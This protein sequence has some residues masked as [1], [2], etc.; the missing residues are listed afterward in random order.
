M[1]KVSGSKLISS[2]T[3]NFELGTLN[4]ELGTLNL[5]LGTLNIGI[6]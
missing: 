6:V 3:L 5:E 2:L 1:F 4:L